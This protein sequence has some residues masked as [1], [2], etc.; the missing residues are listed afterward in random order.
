ML[1][2]IHAAWARGDFRAGLD[3]FDPQIEFVRNDV[4]DPGVYRGLEAMRRGFREWLQSWE[5]FW[6]EPEEFID[7]G[8]TIVVFIRNRGRGRTSGVELDA[9]AA[10]VWTLRDRK[11]TLLAL[12]ADR[13]RALRPAG[14][15]G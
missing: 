13:T 10:S 3:L 7:A 1:R 6:A 15:E 9:P 4:P 11:A 5:F 14:V 12:Y 2:P 8:A